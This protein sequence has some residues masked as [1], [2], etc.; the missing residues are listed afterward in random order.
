MTVDASVLA[1]KESEFMS[2]Y[3]QLSTSRLGGACL[4][5]S[6][7][8]KG[9]IGSG[10]GVLREFW[11]NLSMDM[12]RPRYGVFAPFS[13]TPGPVSQNNEAWD[14]KASE[15][16]DR[17]FFAR[18]ATHPSIPDSQATSRELTRFAGKICALAIINNQLLPGLESLSPQVL[19]IVVED[20]IEFSWKDFETID[21][22]L[23]KGWQWLLEN[24]AEQLCASFSVIE[25]TGDGKTVTKAFR[26]Y[27][28]AED[29]T[30]QNKEEY[31]KLCAKNWIKKFRYKIVAFREGFTEVIP[32][33]MLRVLGP[34]DLELLLCGVPVINIDDWRKVTTY[35]YYSSS[36]V[37]Q[38][39][40]L[41]DWF[42]S[43]VRDD[44]NEADRALLLKFSTGLSRT[45]P[46][47]FLS[48][49]IGEWRFQIYLMNVSGTS[50]PSA[51]TCFNLLKLPNYISR[52]QL[53]EK[54]LMAIRHGTTGF[55][56]V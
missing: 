35:T 3:E 23:F 54:L 17:L 27:N 19:R 34:A 20:K 9:S 12:I 39:Q 50:L 1:A 46:G 32:R 30:D 24:P 26:G 56:F 25:A 5:K 4:V 10:P 11:D 55:E 40:T 49:T 47:G 51:S 36:S 13:A 37:V 33:E 43:I 52:D 28:P 7:K 8:F 53:R 29:V 6:A 14:S 21:E 41:I 42:W 2:A 38:Q 18:D 45:P 15:P 22:D 16:V 31:V 44:M 48:K